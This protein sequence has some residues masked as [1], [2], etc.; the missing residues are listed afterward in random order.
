MEPRPCE[1]VFSRRGPEID[2]S[3]EISSVVD[4]DLAVVQ[5]NITTVVPYHHRIP[6]GQFEPHG[7]TAET[8]LKN[9][10]ETPASEGCRGI[11]H[12]DLDR[13]ITAAPRCKG[14]RCRGHDRNTRRHV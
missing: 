7:L 13:N 9:Q 1:Q 4:P 10:V 8:V 12:D 2:D 14:H 6:P 3:S 5:R 11:V